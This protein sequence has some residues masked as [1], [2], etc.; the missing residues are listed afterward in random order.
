MVML[1]AQVNALQAVFRP[2]SCDKQTT[3]FS[4][5]LEVYILREENLIKCIFMQQ[6]NEQVKTPEASVHSSVHSE[7]LQW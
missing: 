5:S 4:L 2:W 3:N 1:Y 7:T 6:K